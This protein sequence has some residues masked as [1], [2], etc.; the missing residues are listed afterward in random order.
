MGKEFA[1]NAGYTGD[2][3]SIPGLRSPGGGN[4]NPLQYSSLKIPVDRGAWP[5][6]VQRVTESDTTERLSMHM[7]LSARHKTGHAQF[8]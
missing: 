6:T 4:G 8:S 3:G 1:C 7:G 2:A 5:A